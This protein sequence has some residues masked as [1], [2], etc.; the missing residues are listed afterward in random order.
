MT[1]AVAAATTMTTTMRRAA[2]TLI[3]ATASSRGGGGIRAVRSLS[4]SYAPRGGP[5]VRTAS[6]ILS[7]WRRERWGAV[8]SSPSSFSTASGGATD[9]SPSDAS[10]DIEQPA[11]SDPID[12]ESEA[13][14][15]EASSSS[16][17]SSSS[18]TDAR[19]PSR[20]EELELQVKSLK[21]QLLRSLAEMENVRR[22]AKRDV[23]SAKSFAISS[24]AKTLLDTSDNLGRALESV[25]DA[26]LDDLRGNAA[27][28]DGGGDDDGGDAIGATLLT[29]YEGIEMT[30]V[31]LI[32]ALEKNGVKRF[33]DAGDPFDPNVHEAMF[34]YVGEGDDAVPGTVGQVRYLTFSPIFWFFC[35]RFF[36]PKKS[37]FKF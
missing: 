15:G 11:A 35:S 7:P 4:S 19:P 21:D 12:T 34:E 17:S 18:S 8:A 23:S 25:D 27:D 2:A 36:V 37:V 31:G 33:G 29:L 9:S 13:E 20:E 6:T 10:D 28:G 32:K 16:S 1:P 14:T 26:T 5:T 3:N 30:D 24:F 22:I